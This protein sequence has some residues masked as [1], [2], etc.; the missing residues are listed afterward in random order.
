MTRDEFLAL[1]TECLT[2]AVNAKPE[3][4]A[5]NAVYAPTVAAKMFVAM[6]ER[7]PVSVNISGSPGFKRLAKRLGIKFT[8]KNIVA[9]FNGCTV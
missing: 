6:C 2:E 3:E 4:F 9:A 1:Y 5:Y 8:V 7:G